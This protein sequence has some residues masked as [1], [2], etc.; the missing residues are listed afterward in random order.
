MKEHQNL[1]NNSNICPKMDKFA[2][3]KERRN[4]EFPMY[5]NAENEKQ[6]NKNLSFSWQTINKI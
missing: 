3:K 5:D 1:S 6:T 4:F 2:L